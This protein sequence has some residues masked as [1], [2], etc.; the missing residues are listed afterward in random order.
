M[1]QHGLFD[2]Q[3]RHEKI[4][5]YATMLNQLNSIIDWEEF[6]ST[7]EIIRN[8]ERKSNAGR[9]PFEVI[10]MFKILILQSLYNLS[11]E[12]M[13][14]QITD[15]FSFMAFL[16]LQLNDDIPDEKTIWL[17]RDELTKAGLIDPLFEQFDAILTTNGFTAKKGQII[18]ATIVSAPRQRNNH[19]E[20]KQIKEGNPPEEWESKPNKKRQ[21]DVDARWTKKRNVNYFGYKNHVN[22]D[23]KH[24]FIRQYEV[25]SASVHDSQVLEGLLNESNSSKKVYADSAYSGAKISNFLKEQ[26]LQNHINKKGYRNRPLTLKQQ[27]SNQTKSKTRCRVEHVFGVQSQRAGGLFLRCI[28]IVRAKTKIGLQNLSYNMSRYAMLKGNGS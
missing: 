9:K 4:K 11:D 7:L 28:G 26:G 18:D 5:Q 13:E 6:R 16:E 23:A 19:D 15:R 27:A 21:K 10:L 24:K 8:K 12:Q 17:F 25:T 14:F 22:V 3:M 20:N 1:H 2:I